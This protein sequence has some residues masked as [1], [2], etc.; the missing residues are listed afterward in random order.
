M[1]LH[2]SDLK[3]PLI[4]SPVKAKTKQALRDM[5]RIRNKKHLVKFI[6]HKEYTVRSR[7]AW[8]ADIVSQLESQGADR[9]AIEIDDTKISIGTQFFMIPKLVETEIKE[10]RG[11]AT[12]FTFGDKKCEYKAGTVTNSKYVTGYG[13]YQVVREWDEE[14]FYLSYL[15]DFISISAFAEYYGM[16]EQQACN[17]I[18]YVRSNQPD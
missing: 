4:T 3:L 8:I 9:S 18:D 12:Y 2:S 1:L 10:V 15:N 5:L 14:D 6:P 13:S 16:E 7:N 17:I 11:T